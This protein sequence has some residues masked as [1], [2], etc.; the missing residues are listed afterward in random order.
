MTYYREATLATT[1]LLDLI[2]KAEN[3]VQTRVKLGINSKMPS[4]YPAPLF[5][6]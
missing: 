5:Y 4:R 2:V 1:E 6:S 3:K